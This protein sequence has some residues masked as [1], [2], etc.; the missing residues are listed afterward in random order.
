[1]TNSIKSLQQYLQ[2]ATAQY[3]I[4]GVNPEEA[5][6]YQKI[7]EYSGWH[8]QNFNIVALSA[9]PEVNNHYVREV[10]KCPV[11]LKSQTS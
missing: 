9:T 8:N 4:L 5:G 3:D 1:M 2:E 10:L 6:T 7:A 11:S